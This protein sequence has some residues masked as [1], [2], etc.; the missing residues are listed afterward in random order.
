[1]KLQRNMGKVRG[2]EYAA[3]NHDA[4]C[5]QCLVRVKHTEGHLQLVPKRQ[6]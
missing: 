1:M 5:L 4:T 3:F 2:V 6:F